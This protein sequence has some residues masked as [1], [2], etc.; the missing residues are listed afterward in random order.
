M[1][2]PHLSSQTP[3]NASPE[4]VYNVICAATSQDLAQIKASSDRLK[5]LLELSGTFDALSEIATQ[6]TLPLQV[7]QQS[8]IQLKNSSLGHW[9]SRKL[10]TDAQRVNIRRRCIELLNEPD[11][12]IAEC[13]ELILAK[14]ARQEFPQTWPALLPE[15]LGLIGTEMNTRYG[16]ATTAAG[17]SGVL[18]RRSLEAMNAILKE[19]I[20]IKMLSGIRI[21]AK[22]AEE[23]HIAIQNYYSI[24]ATV[25]TRLNP[26]TARD[27]RTAEDLLITHLIF[28]CLVKTATWVWPRTKA[29]DQ[30]A[31]VKLE[32]WITQLFQNSSSQLRT[33]IEL[34]INLVSALRLSPEVSNSPAELSIRTLTRHMRLFGKFF[35]R[36]QQLDVQRFVALPGCGDLILYYWS[37]VVQATNSPADYIEDSPMAVFPVQLLVQ[38]MVLFKESLGQWAPVKKDG[39]ENTQVLSQSFVEDAVKLLVTRFIPLDPADLEGWMTD[40][41]EWV[42]MEERDNDLWEFELRP[43]AERVLMTLAYQYRQYVVPLLCASFEQIAT[44]RTTDLTSILQKEAMYCAIGRCATRLKGEIP[45]EQWLETTLVPE[46]RETNSSYPIVKRRIAWLIGKWISSD[47]SSPNNPKVWDVLVY[48]LQDR[49]NGSDAVVRLTAAVALKECV[50]TIP[51][52]IEPFL[53]YLPLVVSELIHLLTEADTMESKRRILGS[54]NTIIERADTHI[55]PLIASVAQPLPEL[56]TASGEEW[57]MK[58]SLLGT[59][60]TLLNGSKERASTLNPLVV[61]LIKESFM[62]GAQ[63]Q[64]DEDALVM[65]Q[66][67][68]HNTITLDD[69]S[70]G[71]TLFE[72]VPLALT[73]LS[74]NFDLLGKIVGVVESYILLDAPRMLQ[75]YAIDFFRALVTAMDQAISLNVKDMAITLQFA[76][77]LAP[78]NLWG[79]A[80]HVSGLFSHIVKALKDDKLSTEVLTEYVYVLARV[81]ACD[82]NMFLQLVSAMSTT[83][84]IKESELWEAILDQW[85]TR[86]DN[87]SEPRHRKLTAMGIASLVATGRDEVLDRLPTEICNLWLD[88]FGEIREAKAAAEDGSAPTLLLYWDQ[89]PET[90]FRETH[91]TAEYDRR[92]ATYEND[93]VRTT[94]LTAFVAAQ[95]Q[96]AE[97]ACGGAAILQQ[98]YLAKADPAVMKQIQDE[99]TGRGPGS[100]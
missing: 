63:A 57:L 41:E 17:H 20:H 98:K 65:W 10:L 35:R 33:I 1:P 46:S 14:I 90:F 26:T 52:E 45:F 16:S 71:V 83:T 95:L 4:E 13:N 25:L 70:S 3:Q 73:L 84:Q 11:D 9:K 85:W 21:M 86:F 99:L 37:K 34:R 54:L 89:L 22:I 18:L 44:R 94:Q 82:K 36:L 61:P 29:S 32:P 12:V 66:A 72:L 53:P 38:A 39:T 28:K 47:C 77:Q 64:L 74:N 42:N 8:I 27:P 93:P 81:A 79:E 24:A 88:V 62:P 68:L 69:S 30:L 75:F 96:Q 87:M 7:R 5:Q 56:W 55:I 31:M 76:L 19:F 78:S 100:R 48:L 40:P 59:V 6:R 58:G 43:C 60:T 15:L 49:G 91:G 23:L 51:F 92:K 50:D 97:I 67:A 80:L 2:L